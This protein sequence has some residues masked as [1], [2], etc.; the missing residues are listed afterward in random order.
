MENNEEKITV[1]SIV[2]LEILSILYDHEDG[3]YGYEIMKIMESKLNKK[4]NP[5]QI[6]PFLSDLNEAGY[7]DLIDVG[8]R[9]KKKYVLN[10][11][12]KRY[13]E[14]LFKRFDDIIEAGI[15]TKINVCLNCGCKIYDGGVKAN[16]DGK[17]V[18]FCCEHCKGN[19]LSGTH[20]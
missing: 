6:Y 20:E 2:K 9:D 10:E 16:I 5:A 3:I 13:V 8:E 17:E 7:I 19:Y 12:G 11:K 4:P 18:Y 15:K 1:N 14:G